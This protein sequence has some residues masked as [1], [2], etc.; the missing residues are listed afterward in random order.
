M[1]K[2]G[3]K[4]T[5]SED[6]TKHHIYT[7]TEI[8]TLIENCVKKA[9]TELIDIINDLK[10]KIKEISVG[11]TEIIKIFSDRTNKCPNCVSKNDKIDLNLSNSTDSTV[12]DDTVIDTGT[13]TKNLY[14]QKLYENNIKINIDN[15]DI[16]KNNISSPKPNKYGRKEG[17]RGKPIVGTSTSSEHT[18]DFGAPT[19]RL[20][21]YVGRCKKD[22][23]EDDVL[24]YLKRRAPDGTFEVVKLDTKGVNEAFRVSADINLKDSLYDPN[25]WPSG[26]TVKQFR[27]FRVGK[28][29][30]F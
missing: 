17:I 22:T 15:A 4:K 14:S 23:S 7:D 12:T 3:Q 9:T 13:G 10:V 30:E 18:E 27:F 24:R 8:Q 28:R 29:G 19:P 11:N 25:F 1:T 6:E 5:P 16:D 21:I 20:W 26:I 2:R